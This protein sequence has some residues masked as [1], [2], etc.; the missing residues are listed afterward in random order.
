MSRPAKGKRLTE[1]E[2]ARV[3][4]RAGQGTPIATLAQAFGT[5]RYFITRALWAAADSRDDGERGGYAAAEQE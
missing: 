5:S 2:Q 3:R 4:E 1:S